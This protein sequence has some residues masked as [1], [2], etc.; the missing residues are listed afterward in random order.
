MG[1][2]L[3]TKHASSIRH[4]EGLGSQGTALGRTNTEPCGRGG[5]VIPNTDTAKR[6][7]AQLRG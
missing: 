6:L 3:I 5:P 2:G 1:L 7:G 4:M